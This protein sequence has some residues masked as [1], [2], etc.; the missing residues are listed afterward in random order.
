MITY[1]TDNVSM[2]PIHRRAVTAWLRSVAAGYGR[3]IG[4]LAYIFC[5]DEKILEVNRRYL[6]HDYYTDVI[7]FDDDEGDVINGDIFISID[8]VCSNSK[9]FG[10]SYDQELDRVIVHGV[11]HLC[12]I[13]DKGPGEREL[14]EAAED[15]ALALLGQF[16]VK[17]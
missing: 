9:K 4:E 10:T 13:D 8:T 15:K 12:G 16:S 6:G 1:Q 14:M 17:R 7:T 5:N 2:P 3:R 11:L